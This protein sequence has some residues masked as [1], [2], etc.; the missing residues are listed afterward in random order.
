MQDF[1]QNN[2]RKLIQPAIYYLWSQKQ[3][4]NVSAG[5]GNRDILSSKMTLLEEASRAA[6]L[7]GQVFNYVTNIQRARWLIATGMTGIVP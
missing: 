4:G 1:N 7:V 6:L 3:K 5:L 2:S